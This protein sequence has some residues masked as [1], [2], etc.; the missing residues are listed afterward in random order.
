MQKEAN[1]PV[2]NDLLKLQCLQERYEYTFLFLPENF[3][4]AFHWRICPL[5][6]QT[7]ANVN[8]PKISLVTVTIRLCKPAL[9]FHIL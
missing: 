1:I 6:P 4:G 9:F 5:I 7:Q 3:V 2:A 8:A